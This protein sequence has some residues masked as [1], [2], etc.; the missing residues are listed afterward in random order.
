MS[1]QRRRH[2]D[3]PGVI[4]ED[5]PTVWTPEQRECYRQISSKVDQIQSTGS[6]KGTK[7]L[8]SILTLT[9]GVIGWQYVDREESKAG[10][11]T[12]IENTVSE[13]RK[14]LRPLRLMAQR[15]E[16]SEEKAADRLE[17]LKKLADNQERIIYTLNQHESR[18]NKIDGK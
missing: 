12:G 4:G 13:I 6:D 2:N 5:R 3:E 1:E 10:R 15:V 18:L 8:I 17:Q 14:D 16:F 7:V 9:I 11:L